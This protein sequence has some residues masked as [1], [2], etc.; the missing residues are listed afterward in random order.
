MRSIMT[1]CALGAGLLLAGCF[2]G[3]QGPQGPQ[4]AQGPAGPGGQQGAAGPAGPTGP[5]GPA[6]VAGAIGPAGPKGDAPSLAASI[7]I[8]SGEPAGSCGA[9]E[10]MIS[11][12]CT[13][14][15]PNY[16]LA[17]NANGAKC[18]DDPSS[19]LKVTVVCLKK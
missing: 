11:A 7:R 16:S 13:G 17:T 5:A 18:G 10:M 12:Y 3:K 4:G 2:E 1:I 14:T 15:A 8:V 19:P 9:D 6:G